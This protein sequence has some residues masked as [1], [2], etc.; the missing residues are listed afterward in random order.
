MV[1][2]AFPF[3]PQKTDFKA[4]HKPLEAESQPKNPE[5]QPQCP[6]NGITLQYDDPIP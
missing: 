3:R 5:P 6:K 1:S 2:A 4:L